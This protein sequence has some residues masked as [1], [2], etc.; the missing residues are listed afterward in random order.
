MWRN[1]ILYSILSSIN[2]KLNKISMLF[3]NRLIQQLNYLKSIF[4]S[5]NIVE[6]Y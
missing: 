3:G 5:K 6:M 2:K 4:P 1:I